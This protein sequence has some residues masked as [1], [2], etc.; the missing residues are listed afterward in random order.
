MDFACKLYCGVHCQ[1]NQSCGT[2]VLFFEFEYDHSFI[3]LKLSK[4][5]CLQLATTSRPYNDPTLSS[6]IAVSSHSFR[7]LDSP[8]QYNINFF[9]KLIS[10]TMIAQRLKKTKKYHPRYYI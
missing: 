3:K 9:N 7:N 5:G 4:W 2:V 1:I 10:V 6:H 8:S